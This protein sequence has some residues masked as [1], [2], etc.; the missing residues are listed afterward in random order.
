MR[1]VI[2]VIVLAVMSSI[3]L[4]SGA[5]AKPA[6]DLKKV[7]YALGADM[8]MNFKMNGIQL[9]LDEFSQGLRDGFAGKDKLRF[10]QEE[11]HQV[12]L[13]FQQDLQAK[14]LASLKKTSEQNANKGSAFLAKNKKQQGVISLQDGLQYKIIQKGKGP[15]PSLDDVVTVNYE[16]RLIDGKVFD[17]S[18]KRGKPATF[19][20][21]QVIQGWQEALQLM[22]QGSK[23]RLFVPPQHAYGEFGTGGVIGPN[24]T[25]IFDVE[26][27]AIGDNKAKQGNTK[28]DDKTH[29]K[30][31]K[32]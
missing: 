28:K 27:I 25:L 16:G 18:Y 29:A 24:Q 30:T 4:V 2:S 6:T 15:K 8:A 22:P 20:L 31:G 32:K 23:W 21:R 17:S 19:P 14:R 10:K 9:S 3:L 13:A 5:V 12:L 26:L 1:T 11:I 7:S